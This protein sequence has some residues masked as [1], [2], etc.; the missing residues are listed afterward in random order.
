MIS[1]S[2]AIHGNLEMY[3]LFQLLW[4]LIL[5]PSK[6]CN[7]RKKLTTIVL[8]SIKSGLNIKAAIRS[9]KHIHTLTWNSRDELT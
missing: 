9:S 8:L 5:G 7:P 6:T 1:K 3:E 4:L 2:M